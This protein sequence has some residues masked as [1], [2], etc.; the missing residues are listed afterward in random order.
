MTPRT[1]IVVLTLFCI[2]LPSIIHSLRAFT[3]LDRRDKIL[4]E[5]FSKQAAQLGMDDQ[6]LERFNQIAR[7]RHTANAPWDQIK[8][9]FGV[10]DEDLADLRELH[11][12]LKAFGLAPWC[13]YDLGIVRGL[14]YYTDLRRGAGMAGCCSTGSFRV[15]VPGAGSLLPL[16]QPLTNTVVAKQQSSTT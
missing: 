14:A 4:P 6:T 1:R 13:E 8:E 11:I 3:L 16:L 9:E 2:A 15:T 12:Q 10:P 7:V 5:E